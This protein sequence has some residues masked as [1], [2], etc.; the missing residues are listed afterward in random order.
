MPAASPASALTLLTEVTCPHC[1][2]RFAP[3]ESLWISEHPDLS[4]DA[5]LGF[6]HARRF[7]PSRFSVEGDAIDEGGYRATK[8]ACPNCHLE[9]P[10]PFYQVP[11]I[12]F[13]ILGA[14]ACGK[15]YFLA[16]MTWKMRQTLPRYFSV[17]MNDADASANARLHQYEEQQFLNPNP[18]QLVAIAK[19]ETQGDL[20]D[21]VNMGDH[22]ITLPRPFMFTLQPLGKHPNHAR[23]KR[24]SRIMCLYDNAGESFLP[25]ADTVSSPVTRHLALSSCLFFCFDPTQDPRFRRA[26]EGKSEDPQMT[27]RTARLDREASVRQDTILLEAIQRVRRHAGLREDELHQRPLVIVVTK[28][29]SWHRLLPEASRDEPYFDIQGQSVRSLNRDRIQ[30]I[31]SQVG[32]LLRELCPEIVAAAEGFARDLTFIP[33]SATGRSPELDPESGSLGIRPR[34]MDPYWVEVPMLYA[35]NSSARGLIGSQHII[36][37][38]SGQAS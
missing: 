6:E 26:C 36:S 37:P 35:L 4:G 22:S 9:V 16:S 23:S 15:S 24:I 3:E 30:A 19:T 7:L 11:S 38:Q 29:D 5:K 17:S 20:Y 21:L 18:D 1:W 10:R 31:S 32:D 2:Q 25:G 12:F 8:M 27:R 34:D 33:V 13:S 28:W 14:P